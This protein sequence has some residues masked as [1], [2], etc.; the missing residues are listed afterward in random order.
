MRDEERETM[1]FPL[2][3]KNRQDAKFAKKINGGKWF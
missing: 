1:F 2:P 3:E